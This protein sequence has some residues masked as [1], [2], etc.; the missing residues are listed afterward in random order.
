MFLEQIRA[1]DVAAQ[2]IERPAAADLRYLSP[3][4]D[5]D[6][7]ATAAAVGAGYGIRTHEGWW[8]LARPCDLPAWCGRRGAGGVVGQ[9]VDEPVNRRRI[10]MNDTDLR[11]FKLVRQIVLRHL[12]IRRQSVDDTHA[13]SDQ[14]ITI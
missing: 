11:L 4:A 6:L 13:R 9:D 5:T 12:R 1:P 3:L 14:K 7:A 10:A 8:W 2:G